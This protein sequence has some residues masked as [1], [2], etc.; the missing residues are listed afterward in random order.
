[1]AIVLIIVAAIMIVV[2]F[3]NT[4]A[5]L[6]TMLENDVPA[7]FK[8]GLALAIILGLGYIPGFAKPSRW[9]FGLVLLVLVLVNYEKII[10]GIK[11]FASGSGEPTKEVA[12]GSNVA[13]G[14]GS[15]LDAGSPFD[16]SKLLSLFKDVVP[17]LAIA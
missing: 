1:M 4:H 6:A 7:Y 3:N 10:G 13:T 9:L 16:P 17:F 5:E 14:G 15:G 11:A 2:A 8:W 12:P